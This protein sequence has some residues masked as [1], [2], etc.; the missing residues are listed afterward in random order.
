MIFLLPKKDIIVNSAGAGRWRA[1]VET[2]KGEIQ[3]CINAPYLAAA[4]VTKAFLKEMIERNSGAIVNIQSAAAFTYFGYATAYGAARYA[5]R[6]F[7]EFLRGDLFDTNL[8]VFQ[9]T[10]GETQSE[11]FKNNPGIFPNMD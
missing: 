4:Y 5:L 11:Y 10:F 2:E 8:K 6:G 9:I 1:L 7:T 3:S